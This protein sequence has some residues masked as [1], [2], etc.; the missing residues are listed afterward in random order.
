MK[1]NN[2]KQLLIEQ[3]KK[4]PIIQVACEKTGIGRASFYRWKKEDS[5]FSQAV[6]TAISDGVALIN[7]MAESQLISAI[8]DK[9]F[10]AIAYWLNHRHPAY[11][12]RIEVTAKLKH[13][14]EQLTPEQEELVVKALKL[15]S[16]LPDTSV[17]TN[18][19]KQ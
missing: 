12:N 13:D 2:D 18:E 5:E 15:A 17:I 10:S 4:T 7:E 14:D 6:E 16:V 3:L 1:T 19:D 9:N 11:A 8:K